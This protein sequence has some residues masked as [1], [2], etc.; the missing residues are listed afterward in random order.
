MSESDPIISVQPLAYADPAL[1]RAEW[2]GILRRTFHARQL[3]FAAGLAMVLGA[4]GY[5]VG[6]YTR[7]NSET[8]VCTTIGALLVGMAVPIRRH[9]P[10]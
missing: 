3:A 1:R 2:R 10:Q 4:L 6:H 7:T 9:A 8:P 5:A